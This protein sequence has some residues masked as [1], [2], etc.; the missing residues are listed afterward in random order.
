MKPLRQRSQRLLLPF[1]VSSVQFM[2]ILPVAVS[3]VLECPLHGR[4]CGDA[5]DHGR[6]CTHVDWSQN[7]RNGSIPVRLSGREG[8]LPVGVIVGAVVAKPAQ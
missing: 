3:H 8:C 5:D 1:A 7:P 4:H 6:E 2:Q